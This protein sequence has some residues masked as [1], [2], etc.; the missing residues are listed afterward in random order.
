MR[1][2][3]GLTTRPGATGTTRTGSRKKI[4]IQPARIASSQKSG[5]NTKAKT[6]AST[7]AAA[8]NGQPSRWTFGMA[9]R[10]E[11]AII[12]RSYRMGDAGPT[13]ARY[14]A[15]SVVTWVGGR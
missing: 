12:G 5:W 9:S 11:R 6:S 4:A 14:S 7:I 3:A 8:M 10:M 1:P 2:S 15:A 13:R